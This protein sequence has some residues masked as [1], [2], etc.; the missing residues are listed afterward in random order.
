MLRPAGAAPA[1]NLFDRLISNKS[2]ADAEALAHETP[3]LL[4]PRSR[5]LMSDIT[6]LKPLLPGA[7]AYTM[8]FFSG[9]PASHA[10]NWTLRIYTPAADAA[11]RTASDVRPNRPGFTLDDSLV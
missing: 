6:R 7:P 1:V 8:A 2:D 5:F 10:A 4:P 9:C 11:K 3:V